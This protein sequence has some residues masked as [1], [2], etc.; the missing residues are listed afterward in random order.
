MSQEENVVDRTPHAAA[1]RQLDSYYD[2]TYPD[3]RLLWMTSSVLAMHMGFWDEQTSDH[4]EALIN[5]NRAL[6]A[7]TDLRRGDRVLDAGC[8]VGGSALW[9]AREIGVEV[10]GIDLVEGQV[11]R[12]RRNARRHGVADR[13]TFERQDITRTAFPDESFD[14]VWAIESACHVPD[15]RE[16]LTEARRLLVPGGRLVVA[17]GFRSRRPFSPAYERL[18]SSWLSGWAVPDLLTADE[19]MAATRRAGFARACLDDV[20][21]NVRPSLRRLYRLALALYPAGV[22][23][24]R[25][26]RLI[27]DKQLTNARAALE[28]YQ[29]LQRG[30]WFYGIAT[31]VA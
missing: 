20:T 8:G 28:Q 26:L 19:F 1:V 10:V 15:K 24:L 5:M 14:V 16:F 21:A 9:M 23:L 11:R 31:A 13:A 27:T 12:A 22:V 17:D 6:A 18:L 25:P 2:E 30:L 4:D 7:R 29:A 3:Y